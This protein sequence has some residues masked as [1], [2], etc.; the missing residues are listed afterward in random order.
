M[1][2]T[3]RPLTQSHPHHIHPK[4][5]RR[6]SSF[7]RTTTVKDT[8]TVA[9]KTQRSTLAQQTQHN[10]IL[11]VARSQPSFLVVI[12]AL[13]CLAL[14]IPKGWARCFIAVPTLHPLAQARNWEL[15]IHLSALDVAIVCFLGHLQGDAPASRQWLLQWIP[16]GKHLRDLPSQV[17]EYTCAPDARACPC[18]F[19]PCLS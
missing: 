17:K 9:P 8:S 14:T 13:V 7:R 3:A 5:R 6:P 2:S 15:N 16:T 18:Y 4:T 10:R 11:P 12:D 19:S 1:C